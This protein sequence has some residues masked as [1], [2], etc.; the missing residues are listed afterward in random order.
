MKGN[1]RGWGQR[2]SLTLLAMINFLKK[3]KKKTLKAF[4]AEG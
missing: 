1:R 3:K 4:I 2:R